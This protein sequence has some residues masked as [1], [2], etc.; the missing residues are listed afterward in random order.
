METNYKEE[1]QKRMKKRK[2][3]RIVR[4]IIP[5]FIGFA[6]GWML[7]EIGELIFGVSGFGLFM[8]DTFEWYSIVSFFFFIFLF[9]MCDR[10]L[11]RY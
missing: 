3:I 10:L 9:S 6:L 8:Y 4:D 1:F 11:Y 7:F 2:K 5:Y